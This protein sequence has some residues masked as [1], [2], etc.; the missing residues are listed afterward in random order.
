[1][2]ERK[3]KTFKRF[4]LNSSNYL[5]KEV[6]FKLIY[7]RSNQSSLHP[8]KSLFFLLLQN[9]PKGKLKRAFIEILLDFLIL[10]G[11]LMKIVNI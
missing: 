7:T 8:T 9:N 5:L 4:P 6:G 2:R 1:M 3:R 11:V 10:K